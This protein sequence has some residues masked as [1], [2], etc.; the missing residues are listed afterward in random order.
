[1]RFSLIIV[2]KTT[3]RDS[4][5]RK[6]ERAPDTNPKEPITYDIVLAV[7]EAKKVAVRMNGHLCFT[8]LARL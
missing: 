1:M 2:P 6:A 3:K 5:K 7:T 4:W 8:E